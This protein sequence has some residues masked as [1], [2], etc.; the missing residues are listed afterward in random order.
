MAVKIV[1]GVV[2]F[3]RISMTHAEILAA[4]AEERG[5][6]CMP[7]EGRPP[8]HGWFTYDTWQQL[9]FQVQKGEH[10]VQ[11]TT[12]IPMVDKK[13]GEVK[14]KRPQG[15]NVFCHCQ[16]KSKEEKVA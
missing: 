1:D 5:C 12:Y 3:D 6:D 8:Y 4:I 15:Y 11:L 2:V 9:G 7:Y 14:G 16:V 13:T 10:G